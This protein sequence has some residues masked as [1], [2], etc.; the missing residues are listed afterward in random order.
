MKTLSQMYND[1]PIGRKHAVSK[2]NL[3]K[4]WGVGSE[5]KARRIIAE[6]RSMDNGDN[7]V[8]VSF[9]CGKGYYRTDEPQEIAAYKA[10][11]IKRA[12]HTFAPLKKVNRVLDAYETADQLELLENANLKAARIASGLQAKDVVEEIKK[13]DP[14]FNKVTMSLIENNRCLPT[15][16]QLSVMAD[17]YKTTPA[18]LLGA[19]ILPVGV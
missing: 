18:E 19:E 3:M 15:A 17:L 2:E 14:A 12:R 6:L 7:Y 13:K 5:R 4:I 11:T 8:I 10:E 1:I 9:S 16:L